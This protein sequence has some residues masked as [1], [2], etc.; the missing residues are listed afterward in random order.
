MEKYGPLNNASGPAD[1][2]PPAAM[3]VSLRT[4][5]D[6]NGISATSF[7]CRHRDQCGAD[8]PRFTT[9]KESFVGPEYERGNGPRLLFLSLDSGSADINPE[10]KTFDAVRRHELAEDVSRLPKNK[11]WYLTHELAWVLLRPFHPHLTIA[12]TSPYFA[13]VNSAKCCQN[14]P[15]R[16]KAAAVLFNNCRGYIPGELRILNPDIIVTQG[17][18]ARD[19]IV[20]EL[21]LLKRDPRDIE[22]ARYETGIVQLTPNK[23]A[24]WL[25]TY[26]P[27]N[28]GR[29]HPQRK[30]CWPHCAQAVQEFIAAQV[31][32]GVQ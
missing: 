17:G 32:V 4:H 9:T 2:E 10:Q 3:L 15:Q 16:G 20:K 12:S 24:L 27:N 1:A 8:S 30:H 11:H 13:H 21:H 18:E 28:Y 23:Q 5:Y 6:A 22:G 19:V 26:H 14:N 25:Q 7:R 29:F 31:V